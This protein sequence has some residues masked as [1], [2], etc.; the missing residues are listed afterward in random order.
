MPDVPARSTAVADALRGHEGAE[1]A[2][3]LASLDV[4][5]LDYDGAVDAAAGWERLRS[6]VDAEQATALLQIDRVE[7]YLGPE[8]L[9]K[10]Y[11]REE[12][13]VALNVK[14][15]S[16]HFRLEEARCLHSRL[17]AARDALHAGRIGSHHVRLLARALAPLDDDLCQQVQSDVLARTDWRTPRE[18]ERAAL[19]AAA[20]A[21]PSALAARARRAVQD[22]CVTVRPR[23]DGM[24]SLWALLPA[25]DAQTVAA[26]VEA[27]ARS[28]N[29]PPPSI[30]TET[31]MAVATLSAG[32]HAPAGGVD[33]RTLAQRRADALVAMA[34]AWLH[35]PGAPL[36]HGM[37]PTVNVTVPLGT[38]LGVDDV[39]GRFADGSP[40][41]PVTAR[42]IAADPTG[43][44]RRLLVDPVTGHMLDLGRQR[45]TPPPDL[46]AWVIARDVTCTGAGCGRP[47][48]TADIDHQVEW[49]DGGNTSP[50][51][52]NAKCRRCHDLKTSR[53]WD[54]RVDED[55][56]SIWI[57][58][59]G[60]RRDVPRP[61][62]PLS[63]EGPRATPEQSPPF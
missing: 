50:E 53:V 33:E 54:H 21:D 49:Q 10:E 58:P 24:A 46:A 29:P 51:N 47:A 3:V 6:W 19:T 62:P 2:T 25:V 15:L 59:R 8:A 4:K 5:A 43:T 35:A 13:A 28:A 55:G 56:T 52:A 9:A 16:A 30:A 44:W 17:P 31:R 41:D 48:A 36:V 42:R 34:V 40:L 45:Y 1:L 14:P 57:S 12:L 38:L 11:C 60:R 27:R 20:A 63:R 37:K 26:V 23:P 61:R 39:P 18:L 22:R 32:P 7:Q